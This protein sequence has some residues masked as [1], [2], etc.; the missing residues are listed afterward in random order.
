MAPIISA[1]DLHRAFDGTQVLKG[2]SLDVE[3][4]EA[5]ALIGRSGD[6][7]SVFLKHLA[8]LL[9]PDSGS[10]IIDGHDLNSASGRQ[11]R[12]LRTRFGFLFQGGA[13]FQS[14]TVYDNVAFPLREKTHLGEQEIRSRVMGELG[15]VGLEG[16]EAKYPAQI[17]GGMVKRAALARSLVLSPEIMLFD[18]PTTGLDPLI[19]RSIHDLIQ[20][21][22]QSLNLTAIIVTHEIPHVFGL[23]ERVALLHDGAMRFE[24]TPDDLMS[25][26]DPVVR[27][28]LGTTIPETWQQMKNSNNHANERDHREDETLPH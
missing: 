27:E 7:K 3:R 5:V 9:K 21:V 6:G 28:F 4:G 23:V 15:R 12:R 16:S 22:R 24:G 11:L 25:S 20:S 26:E 1:R 19:A 2:A 8:G 14:M 13:L 18:E 17:S 10:V